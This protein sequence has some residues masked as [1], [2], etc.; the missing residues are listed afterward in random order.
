VTFAEYA[1][2]G[3]GSVLEEGPRANFSEQLDA[4]VTIESILGVAYKNEWWV[5]LSYMN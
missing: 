3:P 1:N 5:D 2:Y 4:P